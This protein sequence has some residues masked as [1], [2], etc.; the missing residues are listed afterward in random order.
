MN[1]NSPKKERRKVYR[2]RPAD[3]EYVYEDEEELDGEEYEE[4]RGHG[5]LI[6]ALI[7]ILFLAA[8]IGAV[9]IGMKEINGP[10]GDYDVK[11]VDV[12]D[13]AATSTIA[14]LLKED[15]VIRY[16]IVFRA[17]CRLMGYDGTFQLG[18]HELSADMSYTEVANE[19]QKQTWKV[20]ETFTV[21]FPEGT[22]ALK[23]ALMLDE[24][25]ACSTQQFINACNHDTYDVPFFDQISGEDKFIKL[26]GFLYPDTY[27]FE[28]GCEPHAMIQKM[29][30]NFQEKVIDKHAD[31]IAASEY[32][33]EEIVI[34]ASI[35]E[36]ESSVEG[37]DAARIYNK[38]ASVFLN[39][40]DYDGLLESD[41]SRD[42]YKYMGND[43]QGAA[44]SSYYG[45]YYNGVLEYYYKGYHNIPEG[46]RDGYDT[47]SHK[48]L[49]VGAICNPGELAIA[50]SLDPEPDWD[51]LFFF[52]DKNYEYR[53][54]RTYA[55]HTQLVKEYGLS[56]DN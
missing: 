49:I 36:K 43:S 11:V 56:T 6:A 41:T 12:P 30:E 45:G 33:L 52:T 54:A 7:L 16:P 29:L 3:I 4:R 47:Y 10:R 20:V 23:M 34:L 40:L 28:V 51:Y 55:E 31:E 35:V 26:E 44:Y 24:L 8:I 38:V 18:E 48:G 25:D 13:G 53:W 19:L 42:W 39:R 1:N 5:G 27:E 37:A 15:G 50:G 32:T 2:A 14:D 22:T 21:T 46:I 17:F 9:F